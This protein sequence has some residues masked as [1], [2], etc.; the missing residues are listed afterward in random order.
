M[1]ERALA[2]LL[3]CD[4]CKRR[5]GLDPFLILADKY[6]CLRCGAQAR[7]VHNQQAVWDRSQEKIEEQDELLLIRG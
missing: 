4:V 1:M 7:Q 2:L 3:N 6:L 5:M